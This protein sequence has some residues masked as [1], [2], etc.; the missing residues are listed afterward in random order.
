MKVIVNMRYQNRYTFSSL[1]GC[2]FPIAKWPVSAHYEA[3]I[4]KIAIFFDVVSSRDN[5]CPRFLR[6]IMFKHYVLI[7]CTEINIV[8]FCDMI[9]DNTLVI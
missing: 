3:Q 2:F 5:N 7:L 4:I 6:R 9:T 8:F 1:D